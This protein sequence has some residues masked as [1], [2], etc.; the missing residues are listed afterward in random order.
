MNSDQLFNQIRSKKC[1]LCIGLD[2]EFEKLPRFLQ[3]SDHPQFDFNKAIILATHQ[4]AIAYKLNTS[5]YEVRGTTG[6][7]DMEDTVN[8]IRSLDNNI[9][10]IADAKRCDIGN[11]SE[12]YARTFLDN[13][14]FDA[15]TVSP[16]MGFDSVQPFLQRQDKWAIILAVTSNKGAEDF[17]LEKMQAH[18]ELLF[19]T[20]IKTGI[21]WGTRDNI[22][23]VAGATRPE[24]LGR[25][26]KIASGH[27]LLI[28]GVG[29][30]GGELESVSRNGINAGC[31]MIVNVSRSVI[32]A[33]DSE[34]FAQTAHL[35][36][37][38]LHEE[39]AL[40]LKNHKLI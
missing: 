7:K 30:Q 26:R 14:G 40:I 38:G 20:V 3:S 13:L 19:E 10:I 2:S 34:N 33:D 36:A 6:W 17:Q 15:V 18:D 11:S 16:Y 27:F 1:F 24:M 29:A 37:S 8:F 4:L 5:F 32:F 39:M 9:F 31:G 23:F 35:K 25:I 22:M 12:M 21:S 28:P